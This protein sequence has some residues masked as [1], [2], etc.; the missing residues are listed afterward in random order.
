VVG[1]QEVSFRTSQF[2]GAST[3]TSSVAVTRQLSPSQ[4]LGVSVDYGRTITN[5]TAG[6]IT[7]YVGTW[8]RAIGNIGSVTAAAGIREYTLAGATGFRI[9]PAISTG[10]S[11]HLR[12][13][14]RLSL[15]YERSVEQA[16][17]NGTHLTQLVTAT[18]GLSQGRLTIDT[19]GSYGRGTYPLDPDHQLIGRTGSITIRYVLV[20]NLAVALGSS[21]AVRTDAP[22][23][24]ASLYR[25]M[26]TL[27]YGRAWR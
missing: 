16:L 23:P 18:Y 20:Q 21:V 24:E 6:V 19:Y 22:A 8:Q 9:T 1:E 2:I 12:R 14:D 10:F 11:S 13:N 27:T 3:L 25:T 4:T 7:G 15:N 26:V 17:G 5:G